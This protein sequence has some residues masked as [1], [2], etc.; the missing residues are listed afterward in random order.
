M[1]ILVSQKILMRPQKR[2]KDL[3]KLK[4]IINCKRMSNFL[5]KNR[6]HKLK[7]NYIGYWECHIELDWLLI[8]KLTKK[9]LILIRTGTHADLF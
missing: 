5:L 1:L 3:K 2:N 8:Y 6:N 4:D 9:E 7:G